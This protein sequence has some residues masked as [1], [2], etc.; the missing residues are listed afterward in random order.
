MVG[1]TIKVANA[2]EDKLA[3][4]PNKNMDSQKDNGERNVNF[5]RR[6][7]LQSES[8]TADKDVMAATTGGEHLDAHAAERNKPMCSSNPQPRVSSLCQHPLLRSKRHRGTPLLE[9]AVTCRSQRATRLLAPLQIPKNT[10]STP[11]GT[12]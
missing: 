10:M 7:P 3:P 11:R 5:S 4:L 2:G 9:H 1:R 8:P 6:T 12:T